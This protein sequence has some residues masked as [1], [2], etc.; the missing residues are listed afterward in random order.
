MCMYNLHVHKEDMYICI[1]A[2]VNIYLV[3]I[4]LEI[5]FIKHIIIIHNATN[6]HITI[7]IPI[8]FMVMFPTVLEQML[9]D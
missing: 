3:K 1:Y 5:I 8:I 2:V 9:V 6:F 7:I 4:F